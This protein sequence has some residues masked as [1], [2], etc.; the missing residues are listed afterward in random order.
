MTILALDLGS[1]TGFAVGWENG[2]SPAHGTWDIRPR[3]GESP[4]MRYIHLQR[5]LEQ[6]RQA[7]PDLSLVVFE[8]A[9]HRGG[10]AT[11]TG[12]G[13]AAIVEAW[14]AQAGIEH[15]SVHSATL[16]KH[17]TGKGNATKDDMRK[18]AALALVT[19]TTNAHDGTALAW[20]DLSSDEADAI[21]LYNYARSELLP[22]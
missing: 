1:T 3:R 13:S 17:A 22:S 6:V 20:R 4:G 8:Q 11:A 15:T 10:A 2:A 7:Y 18:H 21:L 16:K 12:V 14:C 19:P 5:H 9:H